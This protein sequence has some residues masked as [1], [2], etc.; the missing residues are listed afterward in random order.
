MDVLSVGIFAAMED[1]GAR[2]T[3]SRTRKVASKMTA[4]LQSSDNRAQAAMARLD[5]LENDN[6]G[7]ET[8]EVIDD[9]EASLDDED[10]LGYTQKKQLKVTKRKTRQAKALENTRKAPRTF[11]EL[12]HEVLLNIYLYMFC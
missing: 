6:A 10:D 1:D 12:L 7:L 2:R 8:V 5:A 11:L 4:A 9:D 3:S